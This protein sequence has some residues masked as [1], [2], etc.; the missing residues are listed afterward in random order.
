MKEVYRKVGRVV[1]YEHGVL[2]YV[3]ESGEAI[4]D[5]HL[6]TAAPFEAKQEL[7]SI[8]TTPMLAVVEELKR[9]PIERIVV[10]EG[11]AFHE[12]AHESW[13]EETRRLHVSIAR[14]PYRALIDLATFSTAQVER[15]AGALMKVSGER[16]RPRRIRLAD[17]VGAAL[18]P[19]L[20]G[21]IAMQQWAAPHDGKGAWIE[22]VPV[23]G[24][25]PNWFR[26]SYRIRPVRAWHNLRVDPFGTVDRALPEAIALLAPVH[27]GTL[28]VLCVDRDD[29]YACRIDA[30]D[31][32]AA[33][34]SA[35]WYPFG[36]GCFGAELVL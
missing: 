5:D 26:P 35:T 20:C 4:E 23:Q 11:I 1:R 31:V 8:D 13:S 7:P 27:G 6:F 2:V 19:H 12:F 18:L 29:V 3:D 14:S 34:P 25:P 24:E 36:A 9:F 15:I 33:E 32:I 16:E 28:Q 10:S 17:Q 30:T 22:N 21:R